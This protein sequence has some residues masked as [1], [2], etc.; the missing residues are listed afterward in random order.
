VCE[1]TLRVY[2]VSSGTIDEKN[3]LQKNKKNIKNV[4]KKRDKNRKTFVNV[5]KTLL[6]NFSAEQ[7][8]LRCL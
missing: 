3:V 6:E 5:E 7:I 2:P 1:R 4:K 8:N